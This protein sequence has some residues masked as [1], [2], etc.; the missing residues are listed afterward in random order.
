MNLRIVLLAALAAGPAHAAAGTCVINGTEHRYLFVAEAEGG[1][2]LVAWLDPGGEL[3]S[4]A[5]TAA[6]GGGGVVSVFVSEAHEEGCSRLVP[7]AE[8]ETLL[9]YVDFDRCHWSSHDR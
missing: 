7:G 2:R 1:P 6:A 5:G 8:P 4:A 9:R 3:C